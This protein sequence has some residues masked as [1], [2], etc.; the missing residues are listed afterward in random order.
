MKTIYDYLFECK[1]NQTTTLDTDVKLR[2]ADKLG[3]LLNQFCDIE[4]SDIS[5]SFTPNGGMVG[6]EMFSCYQFKYGLVDVATKDYKLE[7]TFFFRNINLLKVPFGNSSCVVTVDDDLNFKKATYS[8]YVCFSKRILDPNYTDFEHC[9]LLIQRIVDGT[10]YYNTIFY[11]NT[12]SEGKEYKDLLQHGLSERYMI[13][14]Y[15]FEMMFKQFIVFASTKPFYF[16]EA[17]PEYPSYMDF[18]HKIDQTV[19]FMNLFNQQYT[20]NST[21][22]NQNI[23]LLDMQVI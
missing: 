1:R 11:H 18:I 7:V 16:Y 8:Y 6:Q 5:P 10:N 17:F 20:A 21:R 12:Q 2:I 22:L 13:P 4:L 3:P 19:E 15:E 9:N 23:L 14:D